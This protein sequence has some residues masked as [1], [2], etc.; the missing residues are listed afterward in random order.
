[1]NDTDYR[2]ILD[3]VIENGRWTTGTWDELETEIDFEARE[4]ELTPEQIAEA[5]EYAREHYVGGMQ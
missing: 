4:R 3:T 5:V 2:D 1:M